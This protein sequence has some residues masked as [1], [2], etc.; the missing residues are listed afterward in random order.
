MKIAMVSQQAS[1]NSYV[2]ELA[3]AL[4]RTGHDVT[5]Y[6]R[7]EGDEPAERRGEGG[8]RI[9]SLQAGPARPMSRG[10]ILPHLGTF[11]EQLS[12]EWRRS[13]PDV[14]HAHYW[15]S[16]VAALLA[17]GHMRVPV[18]QTYHALAAAERRNERPPGQGRP[19]GSDDVLPQRMR[20][21]RLVGRRA[22]WILATC[23]DEV[24]DLVNLGVP[25]SKTS[26]VP[27]GVN[28][29]LFAPDEQPHL[30]GG[31][32]RLLSVGPLAPHGGLD[33]LVRA[34][35]KVPSAEL[36]IIGGPPANDLHSD[37]DAKR[38]RMQA[39]QAGVSDRIRLVGQQPPKVRADLMRWADAVVCVPWYEPLG[40]VALEAMASG[41]P[42]IATE[43][44][45]LRDSVVHGVTGELVPKHR[46]DALAATLHRLST[47]LV[48]LQEYGVAGR[49]RAQSRFAWDRIAADASRIYEHVR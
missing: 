33:D 27:G 49:D 35:A 16:G 10:E 19:H 15:M 20:M 37:D 38:L 12:D 24:N 22:A 4:R 2:A 14:V 29:E 1:P 40:L 21:E 28:C 17:A 9:I 31:R 46:P 47:D 26:V 23:S 18:V 39:R 32:F 3:A 48:S 45:C 42:V 13:R 7:R 41:T 11:A 44:G 36:V 30:R 34:V 25:R 5:V 6:T 43:V 8:Y